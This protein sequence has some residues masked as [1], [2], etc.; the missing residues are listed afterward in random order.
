LDYQTKNPAVGGPRDLG[1]LFSLEEI[2]NDFNDFEFLE[3]EEKEIELSEGQF[4]TGLGSVIRFVG[5]KK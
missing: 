4:H 5:I 2:K 1:S 3:L